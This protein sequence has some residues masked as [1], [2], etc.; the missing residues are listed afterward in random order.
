MTPRLL[1]YLKHVRDAIVCI[2]K[3]V[4]DVSEVDFLKGGMVADAVIRNFEIIGEACHKIETK[5]PE[6]GNTYPDIPLRFAYEMRNALAHGYYKVDLELVWSSIQT[7]LPSL[8]EQ[9]IDAIRQ[10]Q[11]MLL[12]KAHEEARNRIP[13]N[14]REQ[15]RV[16]NE[17]AESW[18]LSKIEISDLINDRGSGISR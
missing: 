1:D 18:G 16:R 14:I 11:Q 4:S 5:C 12:D 7:D 10:E 15:L 6:F 17:I 2:D 9:I 8:H 3:Y 13:Q